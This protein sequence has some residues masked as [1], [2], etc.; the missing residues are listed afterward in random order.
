M[1]KNVKEERILLTPSFIPLHPQMASGVQK[2]S[3]CT[4]EGAGIIM[5]GWPYTAS[6]LAKL[7][8]TV[9]RKV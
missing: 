2:R 5:E 8:E 7:A 9:T 4:G 6:C 3:Q 1:R